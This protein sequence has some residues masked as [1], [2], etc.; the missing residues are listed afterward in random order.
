MAFGTCSSTNIIQ[1]VAFPALALFNKYEKQSSFF[2]PPG[3][4]CNQPMGLQNGRLRSS[5]MKASSQWDKYHAAFL[6]R[7][8]RTRQGKY[9]G[10]WCARM[11][12]RYQYLQVDF[13]RPSKVIK[14]AMQGRQDVSMWVKQMYVSYSANQVNFVEYMER[15]SRKVND[16]LMKSFPCATPLLMP[17]L[18]KPPCKV[19]FF[20]APPPNASFPNAPLP[21]AP[22]CSLATA[23]PQCLLPISC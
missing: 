5:Q 18:V 12:N 20:N 9:M 16:L 1:Q 8:Q 3:K 2:L 7:L 14:M 10:A 4:L 22:Q 21:R 19:S 13:G 11:N 6:G 23:P 15:N 17:L